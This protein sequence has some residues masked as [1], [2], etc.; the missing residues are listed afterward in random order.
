MFFIVFFLSFTGFSDITLLLALAGAQLDKEL[1]TGETALILACTR[2]RFHF[3]I[4]CNSFG[5]CVACLKISEVGGGEALPD[6][7][8][9]C[10]PRL[11]SLMWSLILQRSDY[12]I[13]H[14]AFLFTLSPF[15]ILELA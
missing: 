4:H 2:V 12:S 11:V 5:F 9:T 8:F 7:F 1:S 15:P 6:F 13:K 3:P 10:Y 14:N